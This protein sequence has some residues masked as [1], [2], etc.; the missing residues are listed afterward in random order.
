MEHKRRK[1]VLFT[2]SGSDAKYMDNN[3]ITVGTAVMNET[4]AFMMTLDK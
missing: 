1:F 2:H 3:E 4:D